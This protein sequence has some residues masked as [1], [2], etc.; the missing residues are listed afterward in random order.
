MKYKKAV[1]FL[2]LSFLLPLASLADKPEK[3]KIG[4]MLPDIKINGVAN[5]PEDILDFKHLKGKLV[6]LDFWNVWCSSCI[7]AFPKME[8]L[9]NE[10]KDELQIILVTRDSKEK[11]DALL[12]RSE[13]ARTSLPMVLGDTLLTQYFPVI[14]PHHVWITPDGKVRAITNSMNLTEYN[15]QS[16]LNGEPTSLA[17]VEL[18]ENFD[19]SIP[20]FSAI[21]NHFAESVEIYSHLTRYISGIF[22]YTAGTSFIPGTE[23]PFRIAF[24]NRSVLNLLKISFSHFNENTFGFPKDLRRIRI[25]TTDSLR[26]IPPADEAGYQDWLNE[27]SYSY[28]IQ[29][30]FDKAEKMPEFMQMDLQRFFNLDVSVEKQEFPCFILTKGNTSTNVDIHSQGGTKSFKTNVKRNELIFTNTP[31][32]EICAWISLNYHRQN[33]LV[34]NHRDLRFS[35]DLV[36]P[37]SVLEDFNNLRRCL[38]FQGLNLIEGKSEFEVLVIRD[39][40]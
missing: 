13:K 16:V 2:I 7:Q 10:Y 34:A 14:Y 11:V 24:Y 12:A 33:I 20:L 6:I 15:I 28:E 36:L 9:Q 8:K 30:P 1:Y 19:N 21:P 37:L 32:S 23:T 18:I 4:N 22:P 29:V 25:E 17:T 38:E 26:F 3:L 40:N 31:L 35:V 39:N 27:H 5:Y